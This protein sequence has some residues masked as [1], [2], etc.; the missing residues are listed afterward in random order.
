MVGNTRKRAHCNIDC[1][2]RKVGVL[3][4]TVAGVVGKRDYLRKEQPVPALD[5][6][7][8][9]N[10]GCC[11]TTGA[12]DGDLSTR[13]TRRGFVLVVIGRPPGTRHGC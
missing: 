13:E 4:T 12:C 6:F 10:S 1:Q 8:V 5:L 2:A 3:L 9:G 7:P 11:P